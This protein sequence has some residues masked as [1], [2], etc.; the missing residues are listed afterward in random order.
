MH[1]SRENVEM[2]LIL[3][4]TLFQKV[5]II[6][7]K[8]GISWFRCLK[9][10]NGCQIRIQHVEKQ[11]N[12]RKFWLKVR[13][14]HPMSAVPIWNF[15]NNLFRFKNFCSV[16]CSEETIRF[17]TTARQILPASDLLRFDQRNREL[18]KLLFLWIES[19]LSYL[20][21]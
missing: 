2:T 13:S 17:R 16:L 20:K 21:F 14:R 6:M 7:V 5:H 8:V 18:T 9:L 4:K 10:K 15:F 12:F 3:I 19:H 1:T 11:K